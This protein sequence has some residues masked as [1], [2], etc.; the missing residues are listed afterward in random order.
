MSLQ[1][2]T[3]QLGVLEHKGHDFCIY[4]FSYANS[5]MRLKVHKDHLEKKEDLIA[6]C[7][8]NYD[9]NSARELL[10]L[11]NSVEEQQMWVSRLRKKNRNAAMLHSKKSRG[12][13]PR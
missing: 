4:K 6:P 12:G 13:S 9:P 3:M 11:A 7:K 8:V 5:L 2:D 1:K 10:L